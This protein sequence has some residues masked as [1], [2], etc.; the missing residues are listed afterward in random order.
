MATALALASCGGGTDDSTSTEVS[1]ASTAVATTGTDR[2]TDES[3]RS[4]VTNPP[5][6]TM[7]AAAGAPATWPDGDPA[8]ADITL[9]RDTAAVGTIGPDGGSIETAATDG[10][11]Y[12]LVVPPGFLESDVEITVTPLVDVATDVLATFA[13]G[14]QLEPEGLT[15]PGVVWLE[16]EGA[17]A[18]EHLIGFSYERSGEEV[19]LG[20]AETDGGTVRVALTHFSGA[21]A[22]TPAPGAGDRAPSDSIAAI[23]N[24]LAAA[25]A[26]NDYQCI[27]AS[28]PFGEAVVAWYQAVFTD[29]IKPVLEAAGT[30]D[31]VLAEAIG[32]TL[33]WR[34]AG[35]LLGYMMC[36]ASVFTDLPEQDAA[37]ALMTTGFVN[38]IDT[39]AD[40]CA[41]SHDIGEVRYILHWVGVAKLLFGDE[42]WS[43]GRRA[44]ER[45]AGCLT[46][47]LQFT[48][49]VE[50]NDPL[51]FRFSAEMSTTIRSIL[52]YAQS[53]ALLLDPS[54]DADAWH[55]GELAYSPR[56]DAA[57]L[58]GCDIV[59]TNVT[60]SP[61]EVALPNL[62]IPAPSRPVPTGVGGSATTPDGTGT[63]SGD[64][65][66][67]QPIRVILRPLRG[68]EFIEAACDDR[69]GGPNPDGAWGPWT[70]DGLHEDE[71]GLDPDW[72]DGFAID[73]EPGPGRLVGRKTYQRT[74][75]REGTELYEQTTFDLFHEA[76][77]VR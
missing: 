33:R 36:G 7:D 13:G 19:S 35:D 27:D 18:R 46:F 1:T 68:S 56:I 34:G 41:T 54:D 25:Y 57:E 71:L 42:D 2:A 75:Y 20:W 55:G 30:D 11:R 32:A 67:E 9:D 50:A 43:W 64:G 61:A 3:T 49:Y 14:A 37:N 24:A 22:G 66:K 31:L 4:E 63:A 10:R 39:A 59:L 76:P 77:R 47:E 60:T 17:D 23:G 62:D 72:K 6:A 53:D 5:D 65:A 58:F 21:G 8:S 28:D 38:A 15:F 48:S 40:S 73:L 16:I 12:R 44:R 26:D 52:P 74:E 69:F 70:F 51:G 29:E 45:V